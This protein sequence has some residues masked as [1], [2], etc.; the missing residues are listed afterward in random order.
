PSARAAVRRSASRVAGSILSARPRTPA[1]LGRPGKARRHSA[2]KPRVSEARPAQA[3]RPMPTSRSSSL[4]VVLVTAAV[5]IGL[6]WLAH[7]LSQ[8]ERKPGPSPAEVVA[9]AKPPKPDSLPEPAVAPPA[10]VRSPAKNANAQR[11]AVPNVEPGDPGQISGR[12]V[13]P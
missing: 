11:P 13:T 2:S 5:L 10:P 7:R 6:G 1:P 8:Q 9:P 3:D 12:V 4:V